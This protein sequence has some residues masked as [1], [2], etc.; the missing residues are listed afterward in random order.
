M[1]EKLKKKKEITLVSLAGTVD[2]LAVKVDNLATTVDVL[3]KTMA[4]GFEAVDKRFEAVDKRF[5]D[6]TFAVKSGFDEQGQRFYS[7]ENRVEKVEDSLDNFWT[8]TNKLS[9]DVSK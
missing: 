4:R 2:V 8:H 1:R 6:L 3:A 7:L 5:D 9:G